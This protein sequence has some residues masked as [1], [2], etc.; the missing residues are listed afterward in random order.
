MHT[1]RTRLSIECPHSISDANAF[2]PGAPADVVNARV[3]PVAALLT[4]KV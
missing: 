3:N 4:D 1:I 2:S